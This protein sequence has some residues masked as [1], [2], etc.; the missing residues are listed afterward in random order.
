VA[1]ILWDQAR[2]GRFQGEDPKKLKGKEGKSYDELR[3]WGYGEVTQIARR[4]E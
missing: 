3:Y 4:G 1:S 2:R